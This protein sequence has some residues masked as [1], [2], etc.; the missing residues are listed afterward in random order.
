ML[1]LELSRQT[2]SRLVIISKIKGTTV[3]S[4]EKSKIF[5]IYALEDMG[6]AKK[7]FN[8]L[9]RYGL[10]VWLDTESLLAGDRWRDKI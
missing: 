7:L 5:L 10:N 9:K 8:N 6:A 3:V 2:F 1:E 4:N